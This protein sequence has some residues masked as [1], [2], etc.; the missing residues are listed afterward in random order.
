MSPRLK[1]LLPEGRHKRYFY[2]LLDYQSFHIRKELNVV[3]D[4]NN[5]RGKKTRQEAKNLRKPRFSNA[6]DD[7]YG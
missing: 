5:S 3:T 7:Q 6:R 4:L 1:Y 2:Q